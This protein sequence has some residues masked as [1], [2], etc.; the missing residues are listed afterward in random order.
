MMGEQR[1]FD[2]DERLAL[3]R[4]AEDIFIEDVA[5]VPLAYP[6]FIHATNKR[7]QNYSVHPVGLMKFRWLALEE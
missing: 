1:T 2:Y 5:G 4:R 7:V 3:L 6:P